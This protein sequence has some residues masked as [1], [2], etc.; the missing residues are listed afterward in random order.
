[1]REKAKC[2]TESYRAGLPAANCVEFLLYLSSCFIE[3]AQHNRFRV[4]F[5]ILAICH[6]LLAPDFSLFVAS[7]QSDS[8]VRYRVF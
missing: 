5:E 1:M 3:K 7:L 8:E 2:D 4:E 6:Y